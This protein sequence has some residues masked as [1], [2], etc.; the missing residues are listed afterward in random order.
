[1]LVGGGGGWWCWW[2]VVLVG[3]GVGG[4]WS[5]I[6]MLVFSFGPSFTI[7]GHSNKQWWA[8][9]I[10]LVRLLRCKTV[11]IWK[12]NWKL[13]YSEGRYCFAFI[14]ATEA[15]IFM[16]FHVVVNF[17]LVN[18]NFKFHEDPCINARALVVNVCTRAFS[19]CARLFIHGNLSLF[20]IYFSYFHSFAPQK[21]YKVGNYWMVMNFYGN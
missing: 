15:Q 13:K 12:I 4:W 2:V 3:S 10:H 6:P 14:S 20:L 17:Y 16:K 9:I 8:N 7:I 19:T 21:S 11:K 5:L 18:L 1:M